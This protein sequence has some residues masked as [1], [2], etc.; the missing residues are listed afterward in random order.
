MN[1]K[2]PETDQ[3][4]LATNTYKQKLIQKLKEKRKELLKKMEIPNERK[5][6]YKKDEEKWS[7]SHME[8]AALKDEESAS[9]AVKSAFEEEVI[10]EKKRLEDEFKNTLQEKG[11][12]SS[13]REWV[14][15]EV[16]KLKK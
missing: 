12:L 4:C 14:K 8:Y 6:K 3:V 10:K 9:D 7:E 15:E 5:E 13:M 16:E 1:T 11:N 2:K